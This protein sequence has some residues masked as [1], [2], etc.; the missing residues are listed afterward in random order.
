MAVW[1]SWGLE[2]EWF[3]TVCNSI[4]R[5]EQLPVQKWQHVFISSRENLGNGLIPSVQGKIYLGWC[6]YKLEQLVLQ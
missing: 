6:I 5:G 4:P 2:T 1:L 3:L